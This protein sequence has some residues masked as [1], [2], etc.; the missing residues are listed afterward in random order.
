MPDIIKSDNKF[1]ES[2]LFHQDSDVVNEYKKQHGYFIKNV[3]NFITA[4]TDDI[5][6]KNEEK[7]SEFVNKFIKKPFEYKE[8]DF[9]KLFA[10]FELEYTDSFRD[11]VITL[12][13][14]FP[15]YYQEKIDMIWNFFDFL[16]GKEGGLF[17]SYIKDQVFLPTK[18]EFNEKNN[19]KEFFRGTTYI[20][21][22]L[23]SINE[24]DQLIEDSLKK[25]KEERERKEKEKLEQQEKRRQKE[26]QFKRN[27]EEEKRKRQEE[28]LKQEELRR[29][30]E[31]EKKQ[32][33]ERERKEKEK[34]EREERELLERERLEKE[35]LENER[36]EKEKREQ[37]ERE[38]LD[39]EKRGSSNS[40]LVE[41]LQQLTRSLKAVSL[42][43]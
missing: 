1:F 25:E 36:L 34:R 9:Q 3:E 6:K 38:R 43:M 33:E 12:N 32:Q 14:F 27:Q 21:E 16:S 30:R 10:S 40:V 19:K 17:L 31:Q 37:E 26:E 11:V 13:N 23:N 35:R 39:K 2:T 29:K 7:A 4:F 18:K 5:K 8:L 24:T 41:K 28:Q 20:Q 22:T 15:W 42:K